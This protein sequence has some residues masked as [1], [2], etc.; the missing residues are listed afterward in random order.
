MC[1][2]YPLD[3]IVIQFTCGYGD[4]GLKVPFRIKQ[5]M[6]LLISHW[7]ENR[8][9]INDLRGVNPAEISFAVTALLS[10][11]TITMA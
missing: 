1:L 6:M 9:V 11:D 5:A 7:Y 3:P 8:M 10:K 2:L 4:D